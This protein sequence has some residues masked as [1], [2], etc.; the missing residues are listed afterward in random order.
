VL[1]YDTIYS[2]LFFPEKLLLNYAVSQETRTDFDIKKPLFHHLVL[3]VLKIFGWKETTDGDCTQYV[4]D[5]S[6]KYS[7]H[8]EVLKLLKENDK[9]KMNA[10]IKDRLLAYDGCLSLWDSL[11][12]SSERPSTDE[13]DKLLSWIV[14]EYRLRTAGL[15]V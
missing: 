8:S 7:T 9:W 11:K 6:N 2:A 5:T 3:P 15:Y 14:A 13:E 4:T 1:I 12:N 10:Q